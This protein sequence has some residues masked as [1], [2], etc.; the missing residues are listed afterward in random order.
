MKLALSADQTRPRR[1]VR[2]A[3]PFRDFRHAAAKPVPEQENLRVEGSH[4][5]QDGHELAGG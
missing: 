3:E 1:R 5:T 4:P 2:R